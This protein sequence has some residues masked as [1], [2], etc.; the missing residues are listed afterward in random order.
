[1]IQ[2]RVAKQE[3]V[4]AEPAA[5]LAVYLATGAADVL[6]GRYVFATDDVPH[7]IS[8]AKDIQEQDLYMLRGRPQY[9]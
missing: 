2:G 1:M 5:R 8:R 6:S 9:H 7:M 3:N 4:S